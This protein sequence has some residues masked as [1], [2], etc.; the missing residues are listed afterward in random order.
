MRRTLAILSFIAGISLASPPLRAQGNDAAQAQF[1]DAFLNV[2]KG[3]DL[4]KAGD[5]KAALATYRSALATL[6]KIKQ[7]NP[8]WQ[9]ELLDF[10]IKRTTEAMERLQEK[11][12]GTGKPGGNDLGLPPVKPLD[13]DDIPGNTPPRALPKGKGPKGAATGDAVDAVKQQME[14]LRN[15]LAEAER[16]LRDEQEKNTKLTADIADAMAARKKAEDARTKAQQLAQVFET[17]IHELKT[18]GDANGARAK[19]LEAKL[20]AA[21]RNS[22]ETQADLAAA[23]ERITQLLGRSR[24]MAEA[25]GQAGTL[26]AQV[27]SLQAK[28]EAEQKATAQQGE[29]AKK[30]EADLKAQIA[31]LS[32]EKAESAGAVAEMKSLQAKL[33]AEQKT[34]ASEAMKAKKREED[35]KGQIASLTKERNDVKD[36]LVRLREMNQHTDKLMADNASLLKKLGDAEKQILEFKTTGASRDKDIAALRK[37][38]TDTQNALVASDHKNTSMQ[39]EI[40]ELQKKVSDYSKQIA[41]F[42][43][44]SKATAEERKKME[45]EN[46]LLQGIVMRVLQEDANRAQRKKMIQS[47]VGKLHIQSDALLQQIGYLSQPVVKLSA[48]ERKLFKKP[49]LDVQAVNELVAVKTVA[50]QPPAEPPVPANSTEPPKPAGETTPEPAPAPKPPEPAASTPPEPAKPPAETVKNDTPPSTAKPKAGDDLPAKDEPAPKPP[51]TKSAD[52]SAPPPVKNAPSSGGAKL[53]SDVK[54]IAEQA[55]KAFE[56]EK[57]ADAEKLYDKTLQMAPNNVYLQSNKAVVQFR[58]GKF[59]QSEESFKKALA[60]APEDAFCWS[61]LGIVYYSEEKF[62]DAVNALTK[63][64]AINPRNPTAHNYLGITAAQKGWLEAAQKELESA[65]QLDPKYADAWYNLAITLATKQPPDK[66]GAKKAYDKAIELGI[67]KDGA[68]E[69]LLSK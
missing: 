60:I 62:D 29:Q 34:S 22:A 23:E 31:A 9:T 47:E 63:S 52:G 3:E 13:M 7:E 36:E 49:V 19:E 39:A 46:R 53:P 65:V 58:M 1:V 18:A 32:K 55:K 30:R 64:L 42:K 51:E 26:P 69:S 61:T 48:L 10:R 12:G 38:V 59:K 43:A 24:K 41:Q 16:R 6:V 2:R 14:D 66:E 11:M 27:K 20:A 5:Q 54:P 56:A 50:T 17:S 25:A 15:Q 44:D 57:F 33:D 68:M 4:E 35:L 67:P 45:D 21:N 40:A 8:N 37:Q 28:L